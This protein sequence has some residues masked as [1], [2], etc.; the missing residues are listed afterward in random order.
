MYLS[1]RENMDE[2]NLGD[3]RYKVNPVLCIREEFR[4]RERQH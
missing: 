4:R 2:S 3:G 1:I